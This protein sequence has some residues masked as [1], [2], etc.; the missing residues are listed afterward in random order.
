MRDPSTF[1]SRFADAVGRFADLAPVDVEPVSMTLAVTAA[2]ASR[3]TV[4]LGAPFNFSRI[5]MLVLLMVLVIAA[6][7]AAMIGAGLFRAPIPA[8]HGVFA[9]TGLMMEMRIDATAT[10]LPDGR[11]L[12]A[13]GWNQLRT[14]LAGGE[15]DVSTRAL[16]T[17]E[18]FDPATETFS[19][20]GPLIQARRDATATLL[21]DGRVLIAG[22]FRSAPTADGGEELGE[23]LG[24]AEIFDPGTNTFSSVGA[25]M[26]TRGFHSATLLQDG[27]VLLAGGIGRGGEPPTGPG[28]G[29]LDSVESYDPTTQT[30]R[31]IGN[32]MHAGRYQPTAMLLSD[33]RVLIVGDEGSL[34]LADVFDPTNEGFTAIAATDAGASASSAGILPD[35]RVLLIGEGLRTD[36][37]RILSPSWQV[38]DP[39]TDTFTVL[40]SGGE[41]GDV[42]VPLR[43]GRILVMGAPPP[44]L[45]LPVEPT[46]Q[47]F[48]PA[49]G[50]IV[51][52][53]PMNNLRES[54]QTATL[55]ADGRVLVAGGRLGNPQDI[56]STTN[57]PYTYIA[58][59]SAEL[60]EP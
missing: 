43:D 40:A 14:G 45:G 9:S 35:G 26:S 53:G 38:F 51:N 48:D 34:P 55:L 44:G 29:P 25:M 12:I 60:F 24:S 23:I 49:T 57:P 36:G 21:A 4:R 41:F 13:G 11:V 22:G 50:S 32:P 7:G 20:T 18:I 5:A 16:A 10:R 15:S 52:V 33:G 37:T 1:E 17:A 19:T 27:T 54:G 6:V 58:L 42:A 56:G 31:S 30:F 3:P 47:V 46:S 8:V 28:S 39:T 59:R 2:R